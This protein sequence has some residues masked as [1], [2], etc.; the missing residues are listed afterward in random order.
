MKESKVELELKLSPQWHIYP[1]F[2]AL[3]LDLYRR[4]RIE[5][6]NHIAL[7]PSEIINGELEYKVEEILNSRIRRNKL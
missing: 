5:G 1:V 2:H 6:R 7:T 4:N 3:L